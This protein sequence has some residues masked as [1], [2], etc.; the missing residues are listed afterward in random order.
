MRVA[1]FLT[2]NPRMN[3]P[4]G[5]IDVHCVPVVAFLKIP[6]DRFG[7]SFPMAM[8]N[9]NGGPHNMCHGG[10]GCAHSGGGV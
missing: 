4:T 9:D 2:A 7:G 3:G 1:E 5:T 10:L 6:S 8:N